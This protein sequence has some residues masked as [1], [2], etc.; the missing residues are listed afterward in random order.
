M[1]V[2][3]TENKIRIPAGAGLFNHVFHNNSDM[4]LLLMN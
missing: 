4:L 1:H 2:V 3:Q